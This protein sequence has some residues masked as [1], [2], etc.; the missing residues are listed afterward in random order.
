MAVNDSRSMN[1]DFHAGSVDSTYIS[2]TP[3]RVNPE[4]PPL[5]RMDWP[6][7]RQAERHAESPFF[8]A[9]VR[10]SVLPVERKA[11]YGSDPLF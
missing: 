3:D 11:S 1:G 5:E 9:H 6:T 4:N 8:E 10:R 7:Y 2:I